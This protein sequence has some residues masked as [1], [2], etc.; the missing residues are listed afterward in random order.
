MKKH[1]VQNIL[2]TI[3]III[4]AGSLYYPLVI[5]KK[6]VE[7]NLPAI[8]ANVPNGGTQT[9]FLP[10]DERTGVPDRTVTLNAD[11]LKCK[12]EAVF[13][14]GA[15]VEVKYDLYGRMQEAK[16]TNK[17]GV[18]QISKFTP[19]SG[20]LESV[21][22]FSKDGLLFS[23]VEC[24]KEQVVIL[25]YEKDGKTVNHKQTRKFDGSYFG[26][27]Y[28]A[29]GVVKEEYFG[30]HEAGVQKATVYQDDG[31]TVKAE[32]KKTSGVNYAIKAYAEDGKT[33]E[34][35]G[36]LMLYIQDIE[37]S[38]MEM[39]TLG[40]AHIT[41]YK[42][43]VPWFKTSFGILSEEAL[44]ECR[45]S[46]ILHQLGK[47]KKILHTVKEV[48]TED[49]NR[50][51]NAHRLVISFGPK[52]E[53]IERRYVQYDNA[54]LRMETKK[55]DGSKTVVVNEAAPYPKDSIS[56]D[57]Y[58]AFREMQK[59]WYWKLE[60]VLQAEPITA[61]LKLLMLSLQDVE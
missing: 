55:D 58:D 38:E 56:V 60:Q 7:D 1:Y 2:L 23:K 33:V 53:E 54:I 49:P 44:K 59:N 15:H 61:D 8:V 32:A 28:S 41:C 24:T 17:H 30:T 45:F 42:S 40:G 14:D 46:E 39:G 16:E 34:A 18:Y 12:L 5:G 25:Q 19:K 20:A 6:M 10:G 50:P 22:S 47:D 52:G 21:E 36:K 43:G 3:A 26:V 29:E 27:I 4:A 57:L 48:N 13:R 9:R 37:T 51:K 11:D 35:S 31:S